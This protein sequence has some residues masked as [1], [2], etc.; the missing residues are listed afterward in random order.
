MANK[1]KFSEAQ[2][3]SDLK[4]WRYMDFPK[5]ASLLLD[6]SLYFSRGDKFLDSHE[7]SYTKK[8]LED[9]PRFL[10]SLGGTDMSLMPRQFS[11]FM[12]YTLSH[13]HRSAR[14]AVFVNCWHANEFESAAMWDLY[15]GSGSAIAIESTYKALD[16]CL[17][18]HIYLGL[19]SYIDYGIDEIPLGDLSRA[20]MYKRKSFEHEK[21]VR[22][23]I[24]DNDR[25]IAGVGGQDDDTAGVKHKVELNDLIQRVHISPTAKSW[26]VDLVSEFTSQLDY[27][28]LVNQSDLYTDPLF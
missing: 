2:P 25:F 27:N 24:W 23:I 9:L 20:S 10:K 16:S 14:R 22:C 15:G 6:G 26:F 8:S 4:I 19:V 5:F 12:G 21:E 11:D 18:E 28:F 3:K 1:E 7:G 13:T 17:G